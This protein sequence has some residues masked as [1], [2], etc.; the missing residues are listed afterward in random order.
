MRTSGLVAVALALP[1]ISLAI[2]SPARADVSI[3]T[4]LHGGNLGLDAGTDL[5]LRLDDVQLGVRVDGAWGDEAHLGGYAERGTLAIGGRVLL[6]GTLVHEGPLALVGT[7]SL[8]AR[9]ER[10]LEEAQGP[11]R[12]ATRMLGRLGMVANISVAPEVVVRGGLALDFDTELDPLVS[13]A[14]FTTLLVAGFA[15]A[16]TESVALYAEVEGGSSYGFDGDN[17][18]WLLGATVGARFVIDGGGPWLVY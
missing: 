2:A 9:H 16:P 11:Y 12:S 3:A 1:G 18:K 10:L 13:P 5:R 7:V 14:S 4:D 6:A 8:G 17:E 15:W